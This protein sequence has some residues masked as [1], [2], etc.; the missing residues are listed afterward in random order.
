[1]RKLI[2]TL[3]FFLSFTSAHAFS[4]QV[5]YTGTY[6]LSLDQVK[7]TLRIFQDSGGI[8]SGTL[9]STTGT[10]YTLQGEAKEGMI[11]GVCFDTQSSAYFEAYLENGQLA[12]VLIEFDQNN[13]PDQS[14]ARYLSFIRQ[15]ENVTASN[16]DNQQIKQSPDQSKNI[17]PVQNDNLQQSEI[18]IIKGTASISPDETGDLSWGF[19]F[20]NPDGWTVRKTSEAIL[21]GHNSI[22]GLILILPHMVNTIQE[23]E[24]ELYSGL[25]ESEISLNL[26]GNLQSISQNISAGDYTGTLEGQQVKAR[27]IGTVSP[28]GGGAYIIAITTPDQYGTE[29][30][31]SAESISRSMQYFKPDNDDLFKHFVGKWRHFTTNTATWIYLYPNG[32]YSS[33]YES[34]YYGDLSGGGNWSA[35]GQDQSA[36]RW[37]V[38]GN[39]EQGQ[40]I[41]KLN[42]G[43]EI[44][45]NYRVHEENGEKYYWEYWFNGQHY[46][47]NLFE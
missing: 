25:Q 19:K 3:C 33:Q 46:R 34:S 45:Y 39:K 40:I 6:I 7:L 30:R 24:K 1:M 27:G 9:E 41:I 14:T 37:T 13:I 15:S 16:R 26:S 28:F 47:K 5:N 29:I 2:I 11:Y 35:M 42:N 36:G 43:N 18:S 44:I 38:K 22:P 10:Q 4:N 31:N 21:M 17:D 20:P 23:L 32:I 8:I 12:L